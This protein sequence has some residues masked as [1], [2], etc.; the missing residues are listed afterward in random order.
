MRT[1]LKPLFIPLKTLYLEQFKTGYK[2]HEIR[3]VSKRWNRNNCY[4]GRKVILSKGYGNYERLNG[5]IISVDVFPADE[6]LADEKDAFIDCFGEEK[7]HMDVI[8]IG[9]KIDE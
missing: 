1:D 5:E 8:Y 9:I 3:L 6:L 2:T 4:P 7:L